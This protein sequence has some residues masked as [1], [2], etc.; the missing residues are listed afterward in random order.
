MG[1]AMGEGQEQWDQQEQRGAVRSSRHAES[2]TEYRLWK[3]GGSMRLIERN[4]IR[5]RRGGR[6]LCRIISA[7]RLTLSTCKARV[8]T[9]TANHSLVKVS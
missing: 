7:L 9:L 5:Q 3:V 4:C 2:P 8:Q 1:F 6:A